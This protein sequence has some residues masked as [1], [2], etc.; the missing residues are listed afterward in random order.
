MASGGKIRGITIDIGADTSKFTESIK[1]MD[2]SIKDTQKEL[3]D[4]NKLLKLDP[5]NI[6][7][8]RQKHEQL[9]KAVEE[10]KNKQKALQDAL[11]EAQKAGST[12]E[13]QKQ[14]DALQREL[15]ETNAKL[16][17]LTDEYNKSSPRLAQ[18]GAISGQVAEKTKGLSTASAG[19]VTGML[20]LATKSASTADDLLTLANQTGFTVEELQ[21]MQYASSFIDVSMESMTGSVVKLTKNMASGS[22]V[23]DQL[24]VS[25]TNADGSMRDA[26]DVWYDSIEALSQVTNETERDQLSMELFGK[27]AMEMAGIVDDGG[28]ALRSLGDEAEST[29]LILG[30]D[31]VE[32]AVAFNDQIDKVKNTAEQ[33][34]FK[35]GATLAE[36][37]LPALTEI[38]NKVTELLEWF[39]NLDGGT[40]TLILTLGSLIAL[41]SPVASLLSG[42]STIISTVVTV[43]TT[44]AG[45]FATLT[46]EG[47][48]LAGA[49]TVLSGP[50]GIVI[51][52]ITALVAIGVALY[53]NWDT[54]KA[55]AQQFGEGIKNTFNSIKT[56]VGNVI[57]GIK[58]T[59]SNGFN[60]AL[61]T[62]SNIFN[63]IKTTISNLM[64]G[65]KNVVTNAINAIKGVF[66]FSWSLPDLR[67]PHI[68]VSGG[69]SLRPLQVPH[70]S[71]DW[72]KKAY[73]NPVV[74]NSPTVLPTINGLMGFGDGAGAEIVMGENYLKN[75]LAGAG[76]T[77]TFNIYASQG[78]NAEDVAHEVEKILVRQTN[79]RKAVFS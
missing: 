11:K 43:G 19:V 73:D 37:V 32:G 8:L 13:A 24:G 56:V 35:F 7:L 5:T 44:L 25:I 51:A 59:I 39:G 70:F 45:A 9:G 68:S 15:V 3:K 1:K 63:R 40:Q 10:T 79:S 69:F 33:A 74:F 21:K 2:S 48:L 53:K 17:E 28:Q 20:A 23:F 12:E 78:M 64:D 42:L 6:E 41:I 49:M 29:G 60:S 58:T 76:Q 72:Y 46:A 52:V 30:Q 50:V 18:F 61:Q 47:G 55:K 31:A 65:A 71:I 14:Q 4:I 26:T 62:A 57:N 27:S 16:K 66:N 22:D 34:F 54:V 38:V 67:L 75:M 36:T 77:N